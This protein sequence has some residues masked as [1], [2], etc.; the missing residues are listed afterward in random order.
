M[1][2]IIFNANI[3][4][5][6]GTTVLEDS[7]LA[8]EDRLIEGIISHPY[9][10]Y[11]PALAINAEGGFVIPGIIDHHC[12]AIS[13]APFLDGNAE[14]PRSR[15]KWIQNLNTHMIQGS[16][17]LVNVDGFGTMEDLAEARR[18]TPTLVQTMSTHT[19]LYLEF[20]KY[21]NSGGLKKEH[22][23]NIEDMINQGAVGIGEGSGTSDVSYYSLMYIPNAVQEV[24]G[25]KISLA[26]A[27]VLREALMAQPPDEK[28]ASDLMAKR[29]ISAAMGVL[30][31]L[32]EEC[33]E[34]V[35]RGTEAN[36]EAAKIAKKLRAPF[37]MHNSPNTKSQVMSLAREL[38]N[39]LIACH[40]NYEYK[41][42]D[43]IE[44]AREVK[45]A[46]GWVD[47]S[48]GDFC[49][50]RQY[51]HSHVTALALLE[52]G[53]VDL[54]STDYSGGYWDSIPQL[55]E[56]A[57][58]QNAINIPQ[59]IALTTG[60]VVKAIPKAAPDRGEIAEGKIAD[61]VIAG[62][63]RKDLSNVRTVIIGGKIVVDEG[64]AV[65][66]EGKD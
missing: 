28:T 5:G 4:T 13:N 29:G 36:K 26:E 7:S 27:E 25:V 53:L 50:V 55:L 42:Q 64:T 46:G 2:T 45:K 35:K 61:L 15:E 14:P 17:T 62:R 47:I 31:E 24:T 52:E 48:T 54:I 3:V 22:W 56:Y 58:L 60:N 40:S 41:P 11:E 32:I 12:H 43:A 33:G 34:R 20:A 23:L 38:G 49:G 57:V 16:T 18:F 66:S 59:A 65:P 8:I 51:F 37:L 9:P 39:L 30:K 1:R 10:R 63:S 21:L 19:P 44:V 6:D